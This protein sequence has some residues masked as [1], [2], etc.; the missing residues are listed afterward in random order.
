MIALR[1]GGLR[2]NSA[3]VS[4]ASRFEPSLSIHPIND[5][6]HD[7]ETT[8]CKHAKS[9]ASGVVISTSP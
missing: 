6:S 8:M 7:T 4:C 1:S 5:A 3:R 9:F 2:I